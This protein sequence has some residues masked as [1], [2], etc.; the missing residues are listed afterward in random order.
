MKT[1]IIK[2]LDAASVR[3]AIELELIRSRQPIFNV[4]R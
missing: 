1:A 2:A 3:K 4:K